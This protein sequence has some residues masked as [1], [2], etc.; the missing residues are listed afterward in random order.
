MIHMSR[1]LSSSNRV[2][3]PMY[4]STAMAVPNSSIQEI[5]A[6]WTNRREKERQVGGEVRKNAIKINQSLT[7]LQK[8][9][10]VTKYFQMKH[11]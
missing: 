6:G 7:F 8:T 9:L 11:Y 2:L 5:S 3:E 1:D 4:L 10:M